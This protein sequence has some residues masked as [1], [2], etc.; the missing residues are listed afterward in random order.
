MA[1]IQE[2]LAKAKTINEQQITDALFAY[3]RSIDMDLI[4]LNQGQIHDDSKDVFGKPIGFYSK[5]T[6]IMSGGKKRAGQPFTGY[7]TGAWLESFY[8]VQSSKGFSF[9]AKDYKTGLILKSDNWLSHDL[10][11]LSDKNLKRAIDTYFLPFFIDYF[12]NILT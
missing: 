2:H 11:G 5:T 6:E 3:I 7:D 8:L 9:F 4:A 10:F 1:S 12:R